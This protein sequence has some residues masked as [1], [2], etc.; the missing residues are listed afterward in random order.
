MENDTCEVENCIAG[1]VPTKY[2]CEGQSCL[3]EV[4]D[5]CIGELFGDASVEKYRSVF[6]F[7]ST[8]QKNI[9]LNYEG[10]LQNMVISLKRT[11]NISKIDTKIDPPFTTTKA[12]K[13]RTADKL[14]VLRK[15]FR[16]TMPKVHEPY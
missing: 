9:D 1:G 8:K 5:M 16:P 11:S 2:K 12:P 7:E 15:A 10:G 14:I 4:H 13:I 3:K 6:R